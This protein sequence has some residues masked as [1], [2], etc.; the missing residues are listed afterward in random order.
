MNEEL[1]R[2]I[3]E[4]REAEQTLFELEEELNAFERAHPD[5]CEDFEEWNNLHAEVNEQANHVAYLNSWIESY[6]LG[7]E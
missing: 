4:R 1:E 2:L 6:E 5:D 3:E 7:Y